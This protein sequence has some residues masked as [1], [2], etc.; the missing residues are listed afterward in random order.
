VK[1]FLFVLCFF[2]S[3]SLLAQENKPDRE[4]LLLT[5]HSKD[6]DVAAYRYIKKGKNITCVLNNIIKGKK[7]EKIKGR[8]NSID[9]TGLLLDSTRI[10]YDSIYMINMWTVARAF[11]KFSGIPIIIV[12]EY[13]SAILMMIYSPG[14]I[15]ILPATAAVGIILIC[16][17]GGRFYAKKWDYSL[18]T[19]GD[20]VLQKKELKKNFKQKDRERVKTHV[21][22]FRPAFQN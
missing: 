13:A 3:A 9:S 7:H 14:F 1:N 22:P 20:Y 21:N 5:T 17:R 16:T 11:K 15:L 18:S 10:L 2:F 8:L 12:G 19:Y 6:G 4:I